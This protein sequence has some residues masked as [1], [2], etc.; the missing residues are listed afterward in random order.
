MR[1]TFWRRCS[2]FRL[3]IL[4]ILTWTVQFASSTQCISTTLSS[5]LGS[6]QRRF[7]TSVRNFSHIWL[8][9]SKS[10][11][12]LEFTSQNQSS[13][14]DS[15]RSWPPTTMLL[16]KYDLRNELEF[17][18]YLSSSDS[19]RRRRRKYSRYGNKNLQMGTTKKSS[20]SGKKKHIE[21]F[22]KVSVSQMGGPF[23]SHILRSISSNTLLVKVTTL[24]LS[25]K[26]SRSDFGGRRD[27]KMTTMMNSTSSGPNGEDPTSSTPSNLPKK[28][29]ATLLAHLSRPKSATVFLARWPR[30]TLTQWVIEKRRPR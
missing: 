21:N 25:N 9:N 26:P 2:I 24:S 27:R 17:Q 15:L 7:K 11:S 3:F 4:K 18:K 30:Q 1:R 19:R 29:E 13:R 28:L 6:Q 20:T 22:W 8:L 5:K 16:F 14:T 23:I 10:T 12:S